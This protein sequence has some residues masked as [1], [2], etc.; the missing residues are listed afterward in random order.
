MSHRQL[1]LDTETTGLKP[2][3]G[4][5]V[6]EIACVELIDR[7]LT[8][9]HFHCYL[10]PERDID[11]GAINVHGITVAFLQD[12]PLFAEMA[13]SFVEFISGAELIIHN[14]PFDIGFLN[15]ELHLWKKDS[16]KISE[17]CS[18][19]DTLQ[20]ARAKYV[21]QRNN[22]DALCKRLKIDNSKRE[23]HG[24]LLDA[25]LLAH[26]YLAMTGGQGNFFDDAMHTTSSSSSEIKM[27]QHAALPR[28]F[29]LPLSSI[30]SDEEAAHDAYLLALAS[31]GNCVWRK[32]ES[33]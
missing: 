10:N 20:L 6:I 12:K 2:E 24:A 8:N 1:V 23:L 5:R 29:K 16:H 22:L 11:Q 13:S 4:H 15:H 25:N 18:I 33:E 3:D 19:I 17:Y 30:A 7:K 32:E 26:V 9:N 27:T 14:A 21:G 31:K 28:A